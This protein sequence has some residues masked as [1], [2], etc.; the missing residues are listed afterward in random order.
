MSE[1]VL[2]LILIFVVFVLPIVWAVRRHNRFRERGVLAG[3]GDHTAVREGLRGGEYTLQAT[4]ELAAARVSTHKSSM[5]AVTRVVVRASGAQDPGEG[6]VELRSKRRWGDV[7]LPG[8]VGVY[9]SPAHLDRALAILPERLDAFRVL[10]REYDRLEP[11]GDA[12][13]RHHFTLRAHGA[14]AEVVYESGYAS[15]TLEMITAM[16]RVADTDFL[17]RS[18]HRRLLQADLW[19]RF[20]NPSTSLA[21]RHELFDELSHDLAP[22][23]VRAGEHDDLILTTI[24]AFDGVGS[25]N[26]GAFAL[27]SAILLKRAPASRHL[28]DSMGACSLTQRALLVRV[29]EALGE[30]EPHHVRVLQLLRAYGQERQVSRLLSQVQGAGDLSLAQ[31]TRGGE[32][33]LSV[34]EGGALE[35]AGQVAL[36]LASPDD[37]EARNI[38]EAVAAQAEEQT[39]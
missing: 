29:F 25:P 8:H 34:A 2:P 28:P 10:A 27:L 15:A 20:L 23:P 24:A 19:A 9:T 13:V 16:R 36:D 5:G 30:L 21:E 14:D 17:Q 35:Q 7:A 38:H 37:V 6:A 31:P 26:D 33:S 18:P 22:G 1:I 12:D 32:V 3:L 39:S 11:V 4:R